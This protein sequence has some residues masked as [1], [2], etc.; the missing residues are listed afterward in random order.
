MP[1]NHSDDTALLDCG[2]AVAAPIAERLREIVDTFD[3]PDF[4]PL[5]ET[6]VRTLDLPAD[7]PETMTIAAV[8]EV[9]GITAHTLRYYERI[10]LVDVDRDATGYRLY[11]RDALARVVFVTRLRMSDMPIGVIARYVEL[12]KQGDATQPER[13]ALLQAHR[14]TIMRRSQELAAALAVIDYKIAIY[15]GTCSP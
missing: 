2:A 12:V 15:G 1:N 4:P 5:S 8:A 13:L 6:L 10:G 11:D 14:A 7:L 3:P 9:V